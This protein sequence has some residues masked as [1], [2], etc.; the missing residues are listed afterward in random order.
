MHRLRMDLSLRWG[1][2]GWD[3]PTDLP[4]PIWANRPLTGRAAPVRIAD[5][6]SAEMV[7]DFATMIEK[8]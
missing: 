8:A 6:G 2:E 3:G 5:S 1:D 4:K 7:K